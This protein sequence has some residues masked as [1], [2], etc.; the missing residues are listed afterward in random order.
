MCDENGKG[1]MFEGDI[2]MSSQ[3]LVDYVRAN[4]ERDDVI[5]RQPRSLGD[6]GDM[7]YSMRQMGGAT[8]TLPIW[9]FYKTG[10]NYL[11]PYVID[12]TIEQKGIKAIKKAAEDFSKHTCIR[13]VEATSSHDNKLKFFKGDGCWSSVGAV[14]KEQ[15]V[16]LASGCWHKGTVIHEILHALGFWHEQSRPDRDNYVTIKSENIHPSLLY[17][18]KKFSPSKV[19]Q[20]DSPYDVSSVMHYDG[21][22][23]SSNGR[24]TIVDKRTGRAVKVQ[25]RGFSQSDIDQVNKLYNC[26]KIPKPATV[27][28]VATVQ[29]CV[30]KNKHCRYWASRGECNSESKLYM[31]PNC[32]KSCLKY[33]DHTPTIR[34][35]TTRKTTTKRPTTR[36]TT[37]RRPTITTT[38]SECRDH[39]AAC[40]SWAN[41]GHGDNC[42]KAGKSESGKIMLTYCCKSCK[43]KQIVTTTK[44]TNPDCKDKKSLCSSWATRYCRGTYEFYMKTNCQKSCNFC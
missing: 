3:Q 37:T 18:F 20:S 39:S 15:E 32:C 33:P 28:P 5:A 13:L 1:G 8:M 29:G 34:P 11:V 9:T 27:T 43:K 6:D 36:K 30:D 44:P 21:Y 23:F 16:S 38:Q 25:R 35:T 41:A 19:S 40:H 26:K 7:D 24:A 14:N 12:D 2:R 31:K 17:N 4:Y 42:E 22:A 10:D